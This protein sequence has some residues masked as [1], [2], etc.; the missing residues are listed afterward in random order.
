MGDVQ[1]LLVASPDYLAK[2]GTPLKPA[3]LK[4][5][6]VIAHTTLLSG[7]EWRYVDQGK[8]HRVALQP[9]IETNDA[10]ANI[11]LAAAGHG[12]TPL[13]SYMAAGQ[14]RAGRLVPVLEKF[15]LPALPVHLIYAQRR[16]VAPK[17]RAFIDFAVPTLRATLAA[18]PHSVRSRR[19]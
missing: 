4:L 16:I 18:T 1:R 12:I 17:V 7:G 13:L 3:D 19:T 2:R 14:I 6:S 11:E 15:A 5:H 9:S 10:H 8:S